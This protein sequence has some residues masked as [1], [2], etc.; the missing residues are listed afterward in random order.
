MLPPSEFARLAVVHGTVATVSDPHEIGNVLGIQGVEYMLSDARKVPFKINFG[1]PSCVPATSFETAGAAISGDDIKILL[2]KTDIHYLA[3]M[4]NFPGVLNK[5]REVMEKIA[6]AKNLSKPIDGH[7]PGLRGDKARDYI[8]AGISTDHECVT[9]EEAREK[10]TFGMKIIIREGSAAKNFNALIPLLDEYPE[11]IMFCSDDK[12]PDALIAGHIDK[13]VAK[14]L[15]F[16]CEPMN[17]F[18]A[19]TLNPIQHYQ[20][21]VGL[22]QKGD[23]ADFM[24]IR[25]LENFAPL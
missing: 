21:N 16:G 22:L 10:L 18:R 5:D 11:R 6:A 15:E 17:V 7:S 19:V 24:V 9:I 20:L 1:A 2:R 8:K 23:P 4:M 12:H 13:L 25:S 3:E 14:A